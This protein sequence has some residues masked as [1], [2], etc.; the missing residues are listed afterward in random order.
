ML[1]R[2]SRKNGVARTRFVVFEENFHLCHDRFCVIFRN[3]VSFSHVHAYVAELR[4]RVRSLMCIRGAFGTLPI[5]EFPSSFHRVR[6]AVVRCLFEVQS[7]NVFLVMRVCST[8]GRCISLRELGRCSAAAD[9]RHKGGSITRAVDKELSNGRVIGLR[10][11]VL[12]HARADDKMAAFGLGG[13]SNKGW[14]PA[15]RCGWIE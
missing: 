9:S 3:V 15:H 6:L 14:A 1:Q 4:P 8:G 11:S 7:L 2:N 10:T 12:V 13:A 5:F